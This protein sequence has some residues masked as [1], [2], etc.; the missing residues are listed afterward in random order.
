MAVVEAGNVKAEADLRVVLQPMSLSEDLEPLIVDG[1]FQLFPVAVD[2]DTAGAGHVHGS[3]SSMLGYHCK[4]TDT[5]GL[6]KAFY[7]K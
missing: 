4:H 3:I 2:W 5:R 1:W 6:L 7:T